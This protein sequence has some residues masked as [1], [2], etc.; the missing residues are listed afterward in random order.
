M[1]RIA[2]C[3]DSVDQVKAIQACLENYLHKNGYE[4]AALSSF[5]DPN[6][7]LATLEKSGGWDI[8]LLDVCMPDVLGIDIAK[9]IRT[10][11]D[12]TEFIFLTVSPDYAVAAFSLKAA[13]YLIKPFS[14]VEFDEAMDRAIKPF[15]RKS[16]NIILQMENGALQVVGISDIIF[17]ESVGYRRVIHTLSGVYEETKQTLSKLLEELEHISPGQFIQPYR[18][19]I[20]NLDSVRTILNNR[21]IM[22]DESEILIKRGDFRRLRDIFLRRAFQNG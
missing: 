10:R 17:I 9:R 15:L 20:V 11:N 18:G 19:Y 12:K 21:I 13:H 1:F 6:E 14:Q 16:G 2:I 7:F 4:N 8:V 22:Q 5:T 3:D